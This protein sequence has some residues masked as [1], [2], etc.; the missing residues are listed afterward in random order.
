VCSLRDISALKE[1]ERMK[2]AFVS[3]VSHELRT[4]ISSLKLYHGLLKTALPHKRDE[5]LVTL[6]RETNRLERIIEDLLRLSRLDQGRVALKLAP[7]DLNALADQYVADRAPLAE[8]RGLSLSLDQAPDLPP[9]HADEGMLG[10][11]LSVLLTNALN[12]TPVG[13][14]VVVSTWVCQREGEACT[15]FSVS[16]TGPGI[17]PEEQS[18]LFQ[19]FFRG[20]AGRESGQPGTGLGL[21]IAKEIVTRHHGWIEVV[22]EGVPGEGATF[23]VWL[24]VESQLSEDSDASSIQ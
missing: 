5:Y 7:V 6:R 14:R 22:S 15:G 16:D 4:P 19:R 17:P 24:P 10:Q 23:S 13:G 1:A 18:R 12:Y 20:A 3:N 21:A 2:D 9:V 8:E 11:T